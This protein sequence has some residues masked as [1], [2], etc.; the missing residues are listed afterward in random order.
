MY[1]RM[2]DSEYQVG[3]WSHW[4]YFFNALIIL[5]LNANTYTMLKTIS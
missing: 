5:L 1:F 3:N 2:S 4:I